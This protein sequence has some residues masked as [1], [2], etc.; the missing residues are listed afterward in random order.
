MVRIQIVKKTK[1]QI[2]QFPMNKTISVSLLKRGNC[3]R[4][5]ASVAWPM[6]NLVARKDQGDFAPVGVRKQKAPKN[7]EV[8]G[9][10]FG[11]VQRN[12][13]SPIVDDERVAVKPSFLHIRAFF[14]KLDQ[15]PFATPFDQKGCSAYGHN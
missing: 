6:L 12:L 14:L 4:Y 1:E 2:A 15:K 9:G 8:A 10:D 11:I 13:L 3:T 5:G 7:K